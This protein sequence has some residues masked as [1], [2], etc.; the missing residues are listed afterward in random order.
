VDLAQIISAG[1]NVVLALA[2]I[3]GFGIA[4]WQ[5]KKTAEVNRQTLE[6]LAAQRRQRVEDDAYRAWMRPRLV[7]RRNTPHVSR[8]KVPAEDQRH[9]D[10]AVE[11][12]HLVSSPS[13]G[14]DVFTWRL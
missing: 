14:P 1:A 7:D 4:S 8:S 6:G 5:A 2:A 10:R 9:F 13:A 12:G 3:A 11:E